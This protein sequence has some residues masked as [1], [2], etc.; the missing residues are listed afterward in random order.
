MAKPRGIHLEAVGATACA[1]CSRYGKRTQRRRGRGSRELD[2][3]K[4]GIGKTPLYLKPYYTSN[5]GHPPCPV[6][7]VTQQVCLARALS[8]LC[9]PLAHTAAPGS[10]KLKSGRCVCDGTTSSVKT[11]VLLLYAQ[12]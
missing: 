6:V 3:E 8:L 11:E 5:T 2:F 12:D 7:L 1:V 9:T 10:K 4:P